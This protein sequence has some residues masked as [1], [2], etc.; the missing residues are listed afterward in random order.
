MN[1][2]QTIIAVTDLIL[3][4]YIVYLFLTGKDTTKTINKAAKEYFANIENKIK[5][6]AKEAEEEVKESK[7]LLEKANTIREKLEQDNKKIIEQQES[8]EGKLEI[9]NFKLDIEIR[10]RDKIITKAFRKIDRLENKDNTKTNNSKGDKKYVK[11]E[12]QHK[13]SSRTNN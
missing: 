8:I 2:I 7:K 4:V 9:L 6:E 1:L 3:S 5:K 10:K 13:P 12:E 11:N